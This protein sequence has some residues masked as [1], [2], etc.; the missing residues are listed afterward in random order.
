MESCKIYCKETCKAAFLIIRTEEKKKA[1]E[2]RAK[3]LRKEL[4]QRLELQR[5][6][7]EEKL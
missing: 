4:H 3:Q 2:D 7:K 5:Q 6:K 1:G